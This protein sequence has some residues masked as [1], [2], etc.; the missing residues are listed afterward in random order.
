MILIIS[1]IRINPSNGVIR[2]MTLEEYIAKRK[3][4]D[5]VNEFDIDSKMDNM[6][7][8]VNYVFEYFNQYLDIDEM[9]Q[10][11]YVNQERLDKFRKQLEMYD[12]DIQDWI[13]NIY[14]IHEKHIHRSIISLLKKDD[15]FLLYYKDSEFRSCSYDCYAEL[16]KKNPF[17]KDQTEMLFLFIK[18]Y[19]RIQSQKAI[20]APTEYLTEEINEW[21]EKTW[22]K[23][24]V[25][26]WAFASNYVERF[27]D[28]DSLWPA[29]HKI[30][31][32][33]S[34]RPYIYDYKQK[35]NLFNLN[36]IYTRISKKPFIKGKKQYLEIIMMYIWLHS[37]WGDEDNYWDEYMGKSIK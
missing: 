24:K 22:E 4:E 23:Y 25:N 17:L 18:D 13:V 33:E 31:N 2:M 1:I 3:R 26:I 30:K 34:W 27:S 16:I 9:E 32:M 6:R 29:K 36:T 8:C 14:D 11:T 28:N 21:L 7:I 37:I 35:T 5:K 15:L 20:N 12:Q 19:H 10:K